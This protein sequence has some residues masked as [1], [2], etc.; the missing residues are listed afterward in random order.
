MKLLT[1]ALLAFTFSAMA[2]T[3]IT[4]L[5]Y[6]DQ[7]R[8][9]RMEPGFSDSTFFYKNAEQIKKVRFCYMGAKEKVCD[10]ISDFE[11][12][13]M[14]DY[15]SG[16]HDYVGIKHCYVEENYIL[17]SYDLRDDYH[18]RYSVSR[19]IENCTKVLLEEEK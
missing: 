10:L 11:I 14:N 3:K 6:D 15:S 5:K 13:K 12:K 4:K 1:S 18:T 7:N 8:V 16:N 9:I 17:A 19:K 2:Q